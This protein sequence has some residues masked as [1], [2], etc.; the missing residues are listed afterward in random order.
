MGTLIKSLDEPV[1]E[2]RSCSGKQASK[3]PVPSQDAFTGA[4]NASQSFNF[5]ITFQYDQEP[6]ATAL[7]DEHGAVVTSVQGPDDEDA[8]STSHV[9]VM[10]L[11]EAVQVT[12][13]EGA[14]A[15]TVP[16]PLFATY[17]VSVDGS[18]ATPQG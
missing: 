13:V 18:T 3:I 14:I 7:P 17:T 12:V 6:S 4:E 1:R 8:P 16:E 9:G 2:C 5:D 10:A 15:D 11:E